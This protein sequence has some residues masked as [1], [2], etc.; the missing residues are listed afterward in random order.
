MSHRKV[1]VLSHLMVFLCVQCFAKLHNYDNFDMETLL[2]NTTRSRAL[3]ECV[4]D[5]TKCANKEDKEMKDD[6]FE[7]VT[8]SCA[9][10]TAKEKQKF[11]DAMKALHRSMGESQ[12]ITMFINKMTNM[13]QGGL[14]DTEKTT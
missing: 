2:L 3:F 14:S 11:G 8:T 7:M 10:C 12:I 6:I 1:L 4:R 13:F 5:E 9:N